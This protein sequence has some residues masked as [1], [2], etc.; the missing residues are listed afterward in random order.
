MQTSI[1]LVTLRASRQLSPGISAGIAES[2]SRLEK[3]TTNNEP[4]QS[5]PQALNRGLTP[6]CGQNHH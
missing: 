3:S 1:G 4:I 6:S 2:T 5:A